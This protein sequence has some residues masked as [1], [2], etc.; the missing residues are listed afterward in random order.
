MERE[1]IRRDTTTHRVAVCCI[2]GHSLRSARA[3]SANQS[4]KRLKGMKRQHE[5]VCSTLTSPY[6]SVDLGV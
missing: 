1:Y 5:G 3:P 2:C 6:L 4:E